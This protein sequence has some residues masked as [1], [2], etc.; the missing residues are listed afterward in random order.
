MYCYVRISFTSVLFGEYKFL[1]VL[2]CEMC[3]TSKCVKMPSAASE[4]GQGVS[5]TSKQVSLVRSSIDIPSPI[6]AVE[7]RGKGVSKA[8][9]GR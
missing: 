3:F 6:L 1:C 5:K 9:V 8:K 4:G 7:L 2:Y